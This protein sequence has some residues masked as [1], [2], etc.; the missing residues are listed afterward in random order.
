M[1]IVSTMD[2]ET[3]SSN[4]LIALARIA[5]A[6]PQQSSGTTAAV[7]SAVERLCRGRSDRYMWSKC[8]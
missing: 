3:S 7:V 6:F 5:V 8:R 1:G 4:M 2:W